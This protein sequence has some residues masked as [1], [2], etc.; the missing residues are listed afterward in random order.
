MPGVQVMHIGLVCFMKLF[1]GHSDNHFRNSETQVRV[2]RVHK[3]YNSETCLLVSEQGSVI[4]VHVATVAIH[5]TVCEGMDV[6]AKTIEIT[7]VNTFYCV[8]GKHVI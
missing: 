5:E 2:R 4:W 8:L 1:S 3:N 7:W 6:D